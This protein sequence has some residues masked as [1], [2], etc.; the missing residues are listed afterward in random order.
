[1]FLYTR[2]ELIPGIILARVYFSTR[3]E[4]FSLLYIVQRRIKWMVVEHDEWTRDGM[5]RNRKLVVCYACIAFVFLFL[6]VFP[7]VNWDL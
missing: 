5:A 2:N 4:V 1:M 6:F 3:F 7:G